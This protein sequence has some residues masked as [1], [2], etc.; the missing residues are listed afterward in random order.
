MIIAEQMDKVSHMAEQSAVDEGTG[1]DTKKLAAETL[2][3]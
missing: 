2:E 3:K 1:E